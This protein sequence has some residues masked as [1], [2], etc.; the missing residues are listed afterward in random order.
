MNLSISEIQKRFRTQFGI[1]EITSFVLYGLFFNQFFPNP[2]TQET[3][4]ILDDAVTRYSLFQASHLM[5]ILGFALLLTFIQKHRITSLVTCLWVGCL[6]TQFYFIW[7]AFWQRIINGKSAQMSINYIIQGEF[8]TASVLIAV[9]AIIG[10]ASNYQYFLLTMFL[11]P[12][13]SLNEILLLDVLGVKDIGGSMVIHTFGACFGLAVAYRLNYKNS[14]EHNKNL[15]TSQGSFT[16]CLIG[17]VLLWALW[18]GF[19][20]GQCSNSMDLNLSILNT[21]FSLSASVLGTLFISVYLHDG[22]F[23]LDQMANATLAG[24][25]IIGSGSDII[26]SGFVANMVGFFGGVV[27]TLCFQYASPFLQKKGLHDVAGIF[28]LHFIPGVLGALMSIGFR[29]IWVDNQPQKQLYGILITVLL[30]GFF[31]NLTGI[32]MRS[33]NFCEKESE[34]YSDVIFVELDQITHDKLNKYDSGDHDEENESFVESATFAK[35]K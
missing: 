12:I 21:Y 6:S 8:A 26:K 3:Q 11:L 2:N 27:S 24:G 28:N 25:V 20:G 17:T 32:Y 31:G 33:F 35:N 19:N 7:N 22:K 14:K 18:P 5:V 13:Y 10:K 29:V 23:N 16:T 4:K 15:Q 9:C 1:A 30:S 34:F